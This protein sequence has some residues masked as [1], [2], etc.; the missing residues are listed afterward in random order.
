ML[1]MPMGDVVVLL[2]MKH[3]LEL[4]LDEKLST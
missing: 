3:D 4:R 2:L 1:A